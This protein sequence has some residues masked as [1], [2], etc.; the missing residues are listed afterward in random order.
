MARKSMILFSGGMD[1]TWSLWKVL[2]ETDDE[3]FSFHCDLHTG[4]R[5]DS[6]RQAVSDIVSHL[7]AMFRT[8]HLRVHEAVRPRVNTR[9]PNV[10]TFY[11]ALTAAGD[12]FGAGDRVITGRNADS[13]LV[14]FAFPLWWRTRRVRDELRKGRAELQPDPISLRQAMIDLLFENSVDRPEFTSLE[15]YPTRYQI[16]DDLPPSILD[17]TIGCSNPRFVNGY[18]MPCG[19]DTDWRDAYVN[20]HSAGQC[21]KCNLLSRWLPRY[22]PE[23]GWMA[24]T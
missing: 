7:S 13:D 18:W 17:M 11:G 15:P 2:K 20:G 6:E 10:A 1:S 9:T 24:R 21:F 8:V 3:V 12:G 16:I 23:N 19:N 14:D 4:V 22:L 5:G